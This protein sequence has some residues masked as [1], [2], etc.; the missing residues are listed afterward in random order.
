MGDKTLQERVGDLEDEVNYLN[1]KIMDL[2]ALLVTLSVPVV[3]RVV[4]KKKPVSVKR[5]KASV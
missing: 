1:R 3:K 4:A 5:G 2:G